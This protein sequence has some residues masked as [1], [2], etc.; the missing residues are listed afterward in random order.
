MIQKP[1]GAYCLSF[2]RNRGHGKL[3][4]H[5]GTLKGDVQNGGRY[6]EPII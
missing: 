4:H 2:C 6:R 3:L 5:A 1:A